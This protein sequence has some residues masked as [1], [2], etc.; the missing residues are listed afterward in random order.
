MGLVYRTLRA[1]ATATLAVGIVACSSSPAPKPASASPSPRAAAEGPLVVFLGDS[2]TAGYGLDA[3][4][5]F[6]AVVGATLASEG[7]PVRVV[8]AGVSGDTSAGGLARLEWLLQQKPDVL[9]V[10][11]GANDGLR[12]QP[13]EATEANLVEIVRRAKGSGSKVL[14]LGMKIPPSYGPSYA[15]RFERLYDRVADATDVPL[16]PFLLD[17]VAAKPELNLPDGIHPNAE[18]HR[19]VAGNLAPYVRDLVR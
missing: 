5:A 15:R 13:P 10:G 16:M 1:A 17:G 12:G 3:E 7:R 14:L 19:V 2:L 4:Q 6:P 9:V 11:L 8:N 18:G